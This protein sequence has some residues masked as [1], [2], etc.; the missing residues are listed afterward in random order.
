MDFY[1]IVAQWL[2]PID[3]KILSLTSFSRIKTGIELIL[4]CLFVAGLATYGMGANISEENA[5]EVKELLAEG[6][7]NILSTFILVDVL[8]PHRC[9]FSL[10]I[11]S[12]IKKIISAP[13][14]KYVSFLWY[15]TTAAHF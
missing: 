7:Y 14:L 1:C 11:H 12:Y 13:V 10:I 8:I 6:T 3:G 4:C 2:S 15:E 5:G 9:I